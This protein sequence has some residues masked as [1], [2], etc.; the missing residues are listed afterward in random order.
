MIEVRLNPLQL[1]VEDTNDPRGA[2]QRFEVQVCGETVGTL[3]HYKRAVRGQK[4]TSRH[5]AGA[6]CH[7]SSK[8][9]AVAHIL[10]EAGQ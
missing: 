2:D 7:S 9:T 6:F 5:N 1:T 10:G 8:A 3:T 4:W